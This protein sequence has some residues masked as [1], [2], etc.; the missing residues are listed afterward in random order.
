MSRMRFISNSLKTKCRIIGLSTALA[1]SQDVANW[2][3]I[4]KIGFFNFHPSVRPV[5]L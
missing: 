5:V 3:G 1:N 4:E 2:L